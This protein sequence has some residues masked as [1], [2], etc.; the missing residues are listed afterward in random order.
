M[1]M[2]M[3]LS[4]STWRATGQKRA[5]TKGLRP[6]P[7]APVITAHGHSLL[8]KRA[9]HYGQAL[10]LLAE[11]DAT[12]A[13]C[14]LRIDTTCN[15]ADAAVSFA[16]AAAVVAQIKAAEP[17]LAH[18]PV[19]LEQDD[20]ARRGRLHRWLGHFARL[21]NETA[22]AFAY[23]EPLL[24]EAQALDNAELGADVA[25]ILGWMYLFLRLPKPS[26]SCNKPWPFVKTWAINAWA[27]SANDCGVVVAQRG[28]PRRGDCLGEPPSPILHRRPRMPRLLRPTI[29]ISPG[30]I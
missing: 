23:L 28:P 4:R 27:Q 8:S 3:P 11:L 19:P 29:S 22:T 10:Q 26:P 13:L 6:M 2:I 25:W 12:P 15:Y 1:A 14:R 30:S 7:S 24:A 21:C 17:L 5:T 20:R 16:P 9:S 18:L